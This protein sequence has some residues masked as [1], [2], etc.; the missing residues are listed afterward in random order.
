VHS[1]AHELLAN[2]VILNKEAD[3]RKSTIIKAYYPLA[4]MK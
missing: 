3:E 1:V 2:G 4:P